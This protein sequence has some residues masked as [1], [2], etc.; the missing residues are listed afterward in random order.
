MTGWENPIGDRPKWHWINQSDYRSSTLSLD[1]KK[2]W[3]IAGFSLSSSSER[4]GYLWRSPSKHHNSPSSHSDPSYQV[5]NPQQSLRDMLAPVTALFPLGARGWEIGSF[6]YLLNSN[7]QQTG[8]TFYQTSRTHV[9]GQEQNH[10]PNLG[11]TLGVQLASLYNTLTQGR[12]LYTRKASA[13][14]YPS[15]VSYCDKCKKC[16]RIGTYCT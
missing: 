6:L 7:D 3:R 15:A 2:E 1:F 10:L 4:M 14:P 13:S 16:P 12:E 9:G 8:D 5:G 11:K